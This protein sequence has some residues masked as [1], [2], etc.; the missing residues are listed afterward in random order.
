MKKRILS[1]L[2]VVALVLSLVACNYKIVK[3][4][5]TT[6]KQKTTIVKE[7][8]ENEK[9]KKVDFS[10]ELT[11]AELRKCF[12]EVDVLCSSREGGYA[13]SYYEDARK[14]YQ[15]C[16]EELGVPYGK[17]VTVRGEVS[18]YGFSS[19][20]YK[21]DISGFTIKTN[22]D[23]NNEE[24]IDC[25]IFENDGEYTYPGLYREVVIRGTI[26]GIG[27]LR[28]VKVI[29]P[30]LG[31]KVAEDFDLKSNFEGNI[32]ESVDNGSKEDFLV[33]GEI[34]H[35]Q[36]R[37]SFQEEMKELEWNSESVWVNMSNCLGGHYEDTAIILSDDKN[38]D[39][40]IVVYVPKYLKTGDVG[41]KVAVQGYILMLG[42]YE[43][44]SEYY[45]GIID[46]FDIIKIC[47]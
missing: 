47:E 40:N 32:G 1:V 17:E 29:S 9:E 13:N 25:A 4:K 41:S 42:H 5:D 46:D 34:V 39:K 21:K 7:D 23:D 15:K 18:E 14:L 31:D 45:S 30:K 33:K 26:G 22:L 36:S 16:A 35:M 27:D 43:G 6:K 28:D 38:P 24:G 3:V 20:N 8:G 37:E 19:D 11:A 2:L 10:K 44:D 12:D